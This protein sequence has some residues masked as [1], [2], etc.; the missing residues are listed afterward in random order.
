VQQQ[1]YVQQ[2]HVQQQPY[3][4]AQPLL[5]QYENAAQQQLKKTRERQM[6]L[7]LVGGMRL[8]RGVKRRS[9]LD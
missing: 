6:S 5:D 3:E 1:Q 9:S 8:A 2:Q 7:L 4:E